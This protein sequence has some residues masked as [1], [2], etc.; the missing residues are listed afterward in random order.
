MDQ[1]EP[2]GIT[3]PEGQ[4]PRR[5]PRLMP[6]PIDRRLAPRRLV[7]A[8]FA[9][10]CALALIGFGVVRLGLL[11]KRYVDSGPAYRLS[12]R[13]ITLDPAPPPWFR[14]GSGAFLEQ[15]LGASGEFR[16][17]S[18]LDFDP[19]QLRLFFRRNPW[20]EKESGVHT[21]HPNRVTVR[22]TYREPVAVERLEDETE[23]TVIDRDGV[24]LTREDIEPAFLEKLVRIYKF[25]PPV[26]PKPGQTWNRID[27][28]PGMPVRNERVLTAARLAA[29]FREQLGL[30]GKEITPFS[31]PLHPHLGR[32]R[33]I[34]PGR[35]EYDVSLDIGPASRSLRFL[36]SRGEVE[37]SPRLRPRAPAGVRQAALLLE[38]HQSGS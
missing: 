13:E 1:R 12:Y 32:P 28:K 31:P 27:P 17:F 35:R 10:L 19:D 16:T 26:D 25:D 30:E 34:R 6:P 18:A 23:R 29:F 15:A 4:P 20:V 2:P 14:G 3:S 7:L 21:V 9:A 36:D 8:G 38:V 24:I 22:L 5:F 11:A 33:F 37:P